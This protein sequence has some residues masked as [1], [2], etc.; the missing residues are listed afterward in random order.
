[1]Q[2]RLAIA[3]ASQFR[4]AVSAVMDGWA[5]SARETASS[6]RRGSAARAADVPQAPTNTKTTKRIKFMKT[7]TTTTDG[8]QTIPRDDFPRT[9]ERN[10]HKTDRQS[11]F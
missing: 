11:V 9:P 5:A 2:Y 7:L 6:N 4:C 10:R 1:G 3:L 8:E